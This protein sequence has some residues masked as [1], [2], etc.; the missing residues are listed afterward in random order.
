[1]VHI[2]AEGDDDTDAVKQERDGGHIVFIADQAQAETGTIAVK[3]RFANQYGKLR[4]NTLVRIKVQT[5]KDH[6][7]FTIPEAALLEDQEK[8]AVLVVEMEKKKDKEGN[9]ITDKEGKEIEEPHVHRYV[10]ELGLRDRKKENGRVEI[11]ALFEGKDE[12]KKKVPLTK[13]TLF[14]VEGGHGLEDGDLVALK[15]EEEH[16]E[17]KKDGEKKD[18]K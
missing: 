15:K 5:K 14:V 13:D 12:K 9:A 1:L 10:A 2:D 8:P 3:V 16:E 6:C 7:D 17:E 4:A 18:E 11:R